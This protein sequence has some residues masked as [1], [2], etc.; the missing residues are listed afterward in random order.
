MIDDHIHQ[1]ILEI[2]TNLEISRK[3]GKQYLEHSSAHCHSIHASIQ[4]QQIYIQQ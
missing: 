3:A 1:S 2:V 4:A